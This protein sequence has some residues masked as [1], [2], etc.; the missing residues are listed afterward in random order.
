MK[1]E[2]TNIPEEIAAILAGI[3]KT[4]PE[5]LERIA[6]ANQQLENDPEF[7][8]EVE[9][10]S[11]VNEL[12]VAMQDQEVSRSEYA[13]RIGK[14]RQYVHKVLNEDSRISFSLKTMVLLC[15]ALG[16]QLRLEVSDRNAS[17]ASLSF[18]TQQ[19]VTSLKNEMFSTFQ[20]PIRPSKRLRPE[21]A[22]VHAKLFPKTLEYD[23]N[24]LSA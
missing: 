10:A 24:R 7:L 14:T 19:R 23:E 6:K 21:N 20:R 9:R 12:L 11:F 22:P 1:K 18:Q 5:M 8:A 4:T 16:K 17:A 2:I 3:P 15:H 13:R